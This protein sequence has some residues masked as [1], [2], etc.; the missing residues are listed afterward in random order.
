MV[1]SWTPGAVTAAHAA[2]L[3]PQGVR[4]LRDGSAAEGGGVLTAERHA[5]T[6][7]TAYFRIPS[8]HSHEE[9]TAWMRNMLSLH[10]HMVIFTSPDM[11]ESIAGL[12]S[13]AKE[14]TLIVVME[15]HDSRIGRAGNSSFWQRELER[16]PERA[17][18]RSFKLFW[19]WLSKSWFVSEAI[20]RNP[21]SSEVFVWS[22]IGCFRSP[23]YNGKLWVHHAGIIPP[24]TMLFMAGHAPHGSH[25]SPWVVKR[26]HNLIVAG[27]QMAG[28]RET[29]GR[30][31][32]A[33]EQTLEGY[34]ARD[35]FIGDDQ[36]LLE[37]TCLQHSSDLCAFVTKDM[38][39]GD[40]WFGLQPALH[41]GLS[42]PLWRFPP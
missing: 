8:K 16:D 29:W 24:T 12:R 34:V 4:G 38:V 15:V 19:I 26:G 23:I 22:D 32:A 27:A 5:H 20:G 25:A 17:V 28:R 10:D 9:Y 42:A 21:F 11:A 7:V 39:P 1:E 6:L 13:H 30:F 35:L 2:R 37:S 31:H 36:A 33:F 40:A 41:E 18:H 3:D 14:K